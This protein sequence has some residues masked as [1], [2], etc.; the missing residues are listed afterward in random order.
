ML[1]KP[2]VFPP[3]PLLPIVFSACFRITVNSAIIRSPNSIGQTDQ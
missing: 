3:N 2:L 1:Q